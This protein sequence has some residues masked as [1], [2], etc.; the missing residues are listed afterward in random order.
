[1]GKLILKDLGGFSKNP[2]TEEEYDDEV[3]EKR[4]SEVLNKVASSPCLI[5]EEKVCYIFGMGAQ[6]KSVYE[7]LEKQ[8]GI[9]VIWYGSILPRY[10]RFLG[11]VVASYAGLIRVD[12]PNILADTFNKLVVA[13]MA[14]VY[15][16]SQ[17]YEKKFISDIKM[18]PIPRVY[19]YSV[20]DDKGYFF[21]V[22]DADN[23]ESATG[24]FEIISYGVAAPESLHIKQTKCL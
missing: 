21:Y 3:S 22:I 20:K 13:S 7:N 2:N 23:S 16:F 4:I 24:M 1:M 11:G 6:P 12:N 17:K 9:E 19:D 15:C 5:S 14:G 10:M 18:N 8:D